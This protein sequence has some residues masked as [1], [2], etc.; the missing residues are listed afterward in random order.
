MRALPGEGGEGGTLF[1]YF[2]LLFVA[3]SSTT[4]C[5]YLLQPLLLPSAAICCTLSYY[6]LLLFVAPCSTTF[7]CCLLPMVLLS[8]DER[9]AE[10]VAA[11]GAAGGGSL[12]LPGAKVS[13]WVVSHLTAGK[14]TKRPPTPAH[15]R[16]CALVLS[17]LLALPAIHLSTWPPADR[18]V[19]PCQGCD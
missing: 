3:T 2:L 13:D 11:A 17:V 19:V 15:F 8:P 4:F 7:C 9:V 18:V 6:L 5:C 10:R 1:Y 12:S 16:P 14:E